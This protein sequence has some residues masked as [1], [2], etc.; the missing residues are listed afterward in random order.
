[1]TTAAELHRVMRSVFC[2][3]G[4]TQIERVLSH[5]IRE[6]RARRVGVDEQIDQQQEA[7]EDREPSEKIEHRRRSLAELGGQPQYLA[8]LALAIGGERPVASSRI[9][10][11]GAEQL[12]QA[13]GTGEI[14]TQIGAARQ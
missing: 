7:A 6:T 8:S 13:V 10:R 9:N 3:G 11:D 4:E 1:M 14:E 12:L 2:V 5:A